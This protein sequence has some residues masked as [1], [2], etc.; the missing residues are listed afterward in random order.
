MGKTRDS[1]QAEGGLQAG[2]GTLVTNIIKGTATVDPDEI[3]A[4]ATADVAITATGAVAGDSAIV[5]PPALT[6]GLLVTNVWVSD[7][8]EITARLFNE[9][10][11]AINQTAGTWSFTL[12][13]S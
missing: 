13:R 12:I 5:N 11:S 4:G 1:W 7:A 9:T 8:N 6:A 2:S 10:G 3:G